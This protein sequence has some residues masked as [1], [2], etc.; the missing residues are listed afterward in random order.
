MKRLFICCDKDNRARVEHRAKTAFGHTV[1]IVDDMNKADLAYI[2]GNITPDMESNMKMLKENGIR[3]VKENEN[4]INENLY[5]KILD[6]K[7]R[8][9][10]MNLG[11]E[12]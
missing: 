4:F 6:G 5:E 8:V 10:E 3:T 11:K 7:I 2:V 1:S 9:K 12:R